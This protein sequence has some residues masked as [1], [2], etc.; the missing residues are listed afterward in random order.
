MKILGYFNQRYQ[1][2]T[3]F[4]RAT[5]ELRKQRIKRLLHF[6]IDTGASVTTLLDKDVNYLGIDVKK[7]EKA[8]KNIGGIGG[9]ID[10]F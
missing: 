4:I 6:H 9:L 2:P 8:E 10:I 5:L 1:P 7:L 3:P